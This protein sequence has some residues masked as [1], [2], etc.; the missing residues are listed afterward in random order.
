MTPRWKLIAALTSLFGIGSAPTMAQDAPAGVVADPCATQKRPDQMPADQWMSYI[1]SHDFG[2]L[3][4]YRAS[5]AALMKEGHAL[6]VVFMGDS[7]T[8]FWGVQDPAFFTDGK[9]DRGISGQTTSQ[10]LLRFRQD[11][12]DLHPQAVH[13]MAGTNDVA[14]NTGP[15]TL[16]QVEGNI[17]SM[18]ELAQAHGIRVILGAVPPAA[19]FPWRPQ[20]VPV[21][22]IRALNAWLKDYAAK[23]GFTYVDYYSA[24][25]TPEGGMKPGLADDG[26]HPTKKG[27]A[28]MEPLA[29]TAIQAV[30]SAK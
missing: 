11:V 6:R 14:G 30:L 26:V 21:G 7:I 4:Q 22:T 23:N 9:L 3:C 18:A 13:I 29:T 24:L 2:K 16:E 27:Y 1:L 5:N 17:A 12:I 15:V 19:R 25:S 8:E 28:V 20:V 10:M